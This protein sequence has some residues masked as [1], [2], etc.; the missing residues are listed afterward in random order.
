MFASANAFFASDLWALYRP[1]VLSEAVP[2][3]TLV[4][5]VV[6]DNP[7]EQL[8]AIAIIMDQP[9]SAY[10]K[11]HMECMARWIYDLACQVP[12]YEEYRT[13]SQLVNESVDFLQ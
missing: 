1:L 13:K 4:L 7:L 3:S 12:E 5:G 2:V 6:E 9:D 10:S 8:K 11:G